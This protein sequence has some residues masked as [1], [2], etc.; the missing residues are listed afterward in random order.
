[1]RGIDDVVSYKGWGNIV[2]N[3]GGRNW[4]G[5]EMAA[6]LL[7]KAIFEDCRYIDLPFIW[8]VIARCDDCKEMCH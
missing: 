1:M 3:R 2:V 5:T 6:V 4:R 8:L 7:L